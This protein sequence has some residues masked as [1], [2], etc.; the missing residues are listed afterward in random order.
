MTKNH[1]SRILGE[2][3]MSQADLARA[4]G[5]RPATIND[6]YHEIALSISIGNL[7][8]ICEALDCSLYDLLEYIPNETRS[9][10]K[11]LL[12][13]EHGNRKVSTSK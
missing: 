5:I 2:K 4:T 10:G 7:D 13:E 11:D 1:L 8:K 3:R 6:I 12:I 9:T